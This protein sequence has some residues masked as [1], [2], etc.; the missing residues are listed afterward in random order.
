MPFLPAT[1]D[2]RTHSTKESASRNE[3][4]LKKKLRPKA[5]EV[6]SFFTCFPLRLAHTGIFMLSVALALEPL[7]LHVLL[8]KAFLEVIAVN[9]NRVG[10]LSSTVKRSVTIERTTPC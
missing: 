6:F 10:M 1:T 7:F 2:R 9:I 3:A 4:V 5:V 8:L